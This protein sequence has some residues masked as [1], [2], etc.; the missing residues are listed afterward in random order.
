MASATFFQNFPLL[1]L[2]SATGT[3]EDLQ[4]PALTVSRP[5]P[6][7]EQASAAAAAAAAAAATP[8]P[9]AESQ[10]AIRFVFF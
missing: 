7:A 4:P 3:H 5:S 10:A 9:S 1:M 6:T 8:T 2:S